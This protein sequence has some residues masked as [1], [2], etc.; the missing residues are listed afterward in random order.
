MSGA[1]SSYGTRH[2]Q[3]LF[4]ALGRLARTPMGTL[5][6]L[7]VIGVALA[8]PAGLALMVN[9]LRSAAG[10]LTNAVDFTVHFK[11]GTPLERVQQIARGAR[12]RPGVEERT[13]KN[14]EETGFEE[15]HFPAVAVPVL[16]NV[17]ERHVKNPEDGKE[18]CVGVAAG[19]NAGKGE[20]KPGGEDERAVGMVEPKE[21]G[22]PEKP[23]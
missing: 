4:G 3:A 16:A 1:I 22:Q 11:L 5:L 13:Q 17:D 18:E 2:L 20:T 15:L 10:D 23:A 19:H 7:I 21:R 6:T 8:L 12:E 14:G 9:N